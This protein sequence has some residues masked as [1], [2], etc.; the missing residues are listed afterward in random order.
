VIRYSLCL[1]FSAADACD[2]RLPMTNAW[3]APTP[4]KNTHDAVFYHEFIISAE[5]EHSPP[6]KNVK[7]MDAAP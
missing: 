4:R 7:Y 3:I 6:K 2:T 5:I 1:K